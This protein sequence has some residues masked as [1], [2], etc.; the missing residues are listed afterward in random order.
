MFRK[1]ILKKRGSKKKKNLAQTILKNLIVLTI[2][3]SFFAA[4]I[5]MVWA[6]TLKIPDFNSLDQRKTTESTKIYDRTGEILLYDIHED[7]KS[8][9]VPFYD[10]SRYIKNATVAIE[11]TE[12][13]E[14]YGIRPVSILR[15]VL[16]NIGAGEYSQGSWPRSITPIYQ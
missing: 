3:F 16:A 13:Y 9:E 7:V 5:L 12:F 4:G 10:I 11:D 1:K 6:T 8:T 2:A 15:A 14:H